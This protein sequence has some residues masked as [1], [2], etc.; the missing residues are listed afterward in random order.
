MRSAGD[1]ARVL[2]AV[3]SGG[4]GLV[5][6][7]AIVDVGSVDAPPSGGGPGRGEQPTTSS[8]NT[9]SSGVRIDWGVATTR[10]F[11]TVS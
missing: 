8:N 6:L 11:V 1:A 10:R 4:D 7:E 2:G 5:G 3:D 9:W